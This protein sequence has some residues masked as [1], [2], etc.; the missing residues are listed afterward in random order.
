MAFLDCLLIVCASLV[1][2]LLAEGISWLLIYR[3]ESYQQLKASIER[4]SKKLEKK[5]EEVSGR[6]AAA[7]R[8]SGKQKKVERAEES[9]KAQQQALQMVK[10]KSVLAV[11]FTMIGFVGLLNSMYSPCLPPPPSTP[12]LPCP[13]LHHP[14]QAQLHVP[15]PLFFF[16]SPTLYPYSPLPALSFPLPF[17]FLCPFLSSAAILLAFAAPRHL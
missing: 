7:E 9:L 14:S 4:N 11:G 10:F 17:P 5:K 16:P 2:A 12:S 6:G 15:P 3:T 8:K 1:S 13:L